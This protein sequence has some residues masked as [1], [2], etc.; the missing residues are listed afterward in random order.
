MVPCVKEPVTVLSLKL[1]VPLKI[2]YTKNDLKIEI[3][4]N[5]ASDFSC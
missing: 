4:G 2:L 3:Y 1:P 5:I